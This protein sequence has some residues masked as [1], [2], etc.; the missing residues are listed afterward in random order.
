MPVDDAKMR[1]GDKLVNGYP[2]I[3]SSELDRAFGTAGHAECEWPELDYTYEDA[4][5]M[6]AVW[7]QSTDESKARMTRKV[8]FGNRVLLDQMVKDARKGK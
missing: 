5:A 2:Q 8:N 4:E 6:A 1:I 7:G 3:V